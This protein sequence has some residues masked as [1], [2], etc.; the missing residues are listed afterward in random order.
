LLFHVFKGKHPALNVQE[1]EAE[2]AS[3]RH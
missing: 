1:K 3:T 2:P